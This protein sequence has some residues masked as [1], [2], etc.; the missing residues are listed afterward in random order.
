MQ[1]SRLSFRLFFPLFFFLFRLFIVLRIHARLRFFA[2]FAFYS[3]TLV[4]SRA[5]TRTTHSLSFSLVHVILTF[6]C[7]LMPFFFL[8]CFEFIVTYYRDSSLRICRPIFFYSFLCS[9]FLPVRSFKFLVSSFVC[10]LFFL[11]AALNVSSKCNRDF[12]IIKMYTYSA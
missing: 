10:F 2:C 7:S 5:H 9:Q 12:V 11:S 1:L 6:S 8:V 3:H 4:Y